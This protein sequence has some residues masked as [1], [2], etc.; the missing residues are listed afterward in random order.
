MTGIVIALSISM[1]IAKTKYKKIGNIMYNDCD[2]VQF[3]NINNNLMKRWDSL[4]KIFK[5]PH[6]TITISLALNL[7]S[8]YL[9][10]GNNTEAKRFL[11]SI[12]NFP[13]NKAGAINKVAWH[14]NLCSYYLQIKDTLRASQSLEEMYISL[15]NKKIP[16][17]HHKIFSNYYK[18]KQSQIMIENDNYADSEKVFN[19]MFEEENKVR[20]KVAAKFML[21]RIYLHD[22]KL[23]E[24]R[25]AFEYVI[26]RGGTTYYVNKSKEYL[27]QLL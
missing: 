5:K 15:K 26:S 3:I 13:N 9:L 18:Y 4:R 2:I 24:A 6:I 14:N 8:G 12:E 22:N 7:S 23:N 25:Q 10:V 1:S 19:S 27:D 11:D 16:K 21:G 20:D 17:S